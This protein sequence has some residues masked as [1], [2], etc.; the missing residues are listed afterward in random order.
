MQIDNEIYDI[1]FSVLTWQIITK[2]RFWSQTSH[3]QCQI[4]EW[5]RIL[6]LFKTNGSEIWV[7][8]AVVFVLF[9]FEL[10]QSFLQIRFLLKIS[11]EVRRPLNT[12]CLVWHAQGAQN[13]VTRLSVLY[14][15]SWSRS[16]ICVNFFTLRKKPKLKIYNNRKTCRQAT[17][18]HN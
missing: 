8:F 1:D 4:F 10:F 6:L 2:K 14:L 5:G 13:L 7:L 17:L 18:H 11:S 9:L 12:K 15:G 16:K 3:T